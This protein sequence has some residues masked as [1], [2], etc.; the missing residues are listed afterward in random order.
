MNFTSRVIVVSD[1]NSMHVKLSPQKKA[2]KAPLR[3]KKGTGKARASKIFG[4]A[5]KD[6]PNPADPEESEEEDEQIAAE[7]AEHR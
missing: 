3:A 5:T 7:L 1:L 2:K 4:E 6:N